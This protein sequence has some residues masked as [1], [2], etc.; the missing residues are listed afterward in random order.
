MGTKKKNRK[1][2]PGVP[3]KHELGGSYIKG[4]T[5]KTLNWVGTYDRKEDRGEKTKKLSLT[6]QKDEKRHKKRGR[7]V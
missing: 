3:L 7:I 5:A 4:S 6:N 2:V 1:G